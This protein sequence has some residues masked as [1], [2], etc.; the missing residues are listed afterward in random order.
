ML[1][2]SVLL[3]ALFAASLAAAEYSDAHLHG[4]DVPVPNVPTVEEDAPL[5]EPV[6]PQ[7]I[8]GIEQEIIHCKI[9]HAA[10]IPALREAVVE[11][12]NADNAKEVV[13]AALKPLAAMHVYDMVSESVVPKTTAH[14]AAFDRH[15]HAFIESLLWDK[16]T[17]AAL[18]GLVHAYHDLPHHRK[19]FDRLIDHVVCTCHD[20]H[21]EVLDEDDE[22]KHA[23][24][25]DDEMHL[26]LQQ[27]VSSMEAAEH[28]YGAHPT[29]EHA[30][31]EARRG[32]HKEED[33]PMTEEAQEMHDGGHDEGMLEQD[34]SMG[35][36]AHMESH[37]NSEDLGGA[38]GMAV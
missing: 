12:P 2:R 23:T 6:N 27:H 22:H 10:L 9:C 16:H 35:G 17:A 14:D 19:H 15:V 24:E 7:D 25:V 37:D 4:E 21:G 30:A 28:K 36:G 5:A 20:P 26:Y 1:T 31:N 8:E 32:L 11:S 33:A 34:D 18:Y 13:E 29:H 38:G 3:V